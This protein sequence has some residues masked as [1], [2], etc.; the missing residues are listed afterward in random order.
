MIVLGVDPGGRD[1]GIAVVDV[2]A[3][4]AYST[5]TLLASTTVHR[6]DDGPLTHVPETYL[7]DVLAVIL[8]L[9][10]DPAGLAPDVELIAVEGVEAPNWHHGGKAKPIKPD[11]I[12]A[13][14]QVLGAVLGRS[15]TVPVVR[16]RPGRNGHA[17]PLDAYPGYLAT[18]GKG[19]DK[20]RHER[21][22]YDVACQGPAVL[23][24]ARAGVT[25]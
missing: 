12:I 21:S 20:R 13:T 9:R 19:Q 23:R 22:A 7:R 25:P 3:T 11:A 14:A 1:T 6:A 24:F 4:A 15:W 2:A 17:L 5:P 10:E 8:T 16:V 18:K